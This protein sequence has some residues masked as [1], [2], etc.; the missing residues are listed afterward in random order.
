MSSTAGG[1]GHLVESA[2]AGLAGGLAASWVMER[3]Q[4]ALERATKH[5]DGDAAGGGG[6]QHRTPQTEPATHKAA[7][8]VAHAATGEHLTRIGKATGGEIVH[9]AF[10]GAVG[11]MYGAAAARNREIAAWGGIPFGATVWLVADELGVPLAGLSRRPT[12]Y[13]L[14]D[15]ASALA[16]HLVYGVTTELVRRGL[17]RAMKT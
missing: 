6:Q 7:D 4:A 2:I 11:A 3:F 1:N 17:T 8:A 13:P 15:H 12:A 9:F 10:G 14:R 5:P 16:A